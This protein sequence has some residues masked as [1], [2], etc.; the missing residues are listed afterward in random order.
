MR[1]RDRIERIEQMIDRPRYGDRGGGPLIVRIRGGLPDAE[2][3][4]ATVGPIA[5]QREPHEMLDD[6]EARVIDSAIEM[7]AR[8]VVFSGLPPT[9]DRENFPSGVY[10]PCSV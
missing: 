3:L 8:V 5:I 6:F 9:P 7:R 2:G 4:H 10:L 1:L